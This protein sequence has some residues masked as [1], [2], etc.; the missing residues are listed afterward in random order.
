MGPLEE[1][2]PY[3]MFALY[4]LWIRASPTV[5]VKNARAVKCHF[6]A[7]GTVSRAPAKAG[8]SGARETIAR[9]SGVKENVLCEAESAVGSERLPTA[10]R[11]LARM[12]MA[13]WLKW[14][15]TTEGTK[16]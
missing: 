5:V 7:W 9:S 6:N 12:M 15:S 8:N 14:T 2:K 16:L 13:A 10:D 1:V 4:L 11:Y 3:I